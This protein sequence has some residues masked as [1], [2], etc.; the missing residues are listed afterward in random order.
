MRTLRVVLAIGCL[1]FCVHS[2][3]ATTITNATLSGS[4][5]DPTITVYG[6]GFGTEPTGI[7][8]Y[9]GSTA[10]RSGE[11]Y[12]PTALSFH[13][14]GPLGFD[15]GQSKATGQDLIGLVISE[16]TDTE[17]V[18]TLGP[19]YT[20][21]YYPDDIYAIQPGDSFDVE[22]A[23]A[24]SPTFALTPTPEPSTLA[25]L[26]SGLL[27]PVAAQLRSRRAV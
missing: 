25:L 4:L 23:G 12:G 22:V 26:V 15:A 16:Y 6:S 21:T 27:L 18:F 9:P 17:I 7:V 1:G 13:D 20:K 11:D 3:S 19:I 5:S 2:A 14:M 8:A 24:I 10:A